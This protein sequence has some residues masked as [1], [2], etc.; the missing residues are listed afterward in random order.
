MFMK[1]GEYPEGWERVFLSYVTLRL[2]VTYPDDGNAVMTR[3]RNVGYRDL[4][5]SALYP[6]LKKM[7]KDGLITYQWG[8]PDQGPARRI[9]SLT[10]RG[11]EQVTRATE[12]LNSVLSAMPFGEDESMGY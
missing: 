2:L 11:L 8:M 12:R 3:L 9:F 1:S 7:E 4:E 5:S 6:L 10:D